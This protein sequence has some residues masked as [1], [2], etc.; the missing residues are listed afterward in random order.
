MFQTRIDKNIQGK[1]K[2]EIYPP[3][4]FEIYNIMEPLIKRFGQ[5]DVNEL[6]IE[7]IKVERRLKLICYDF[8]KVRNNN[9]NYL[10]K[11]TLLLKILNR[12][13]EKSF[14]SP[15]FNFSW[16]EILINLL[17]LENSPELMIN[18]MLRELKRRKSYKTRL[19]NRNE[20]RIIKDKYFYNSYK[21][22]QKKVLEFLF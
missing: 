10:R 4:D 14:K 20:M 12:I 16:E 8:P 22:K 6:K 1:F 15:D 7:L 2:S 18:S 17:H 5:K 11:F 21:F 19:I 13:I 3:S 9:I